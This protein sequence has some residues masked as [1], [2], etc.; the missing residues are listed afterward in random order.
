MKILSRAYIWIIFGLLYAP[1]LMLVLFSFNEAGS[2]NHFSS[3]SLKRDRH[4]GLFTHCQPPRPQAPRATGGEG[5]AWS[6]RP[7]LWNQRGPQA[8]GRDLT[9][10]ASP[11]RAPAA[12]GQSLPGLA[13]PG[14][15]GEG[16]PDPSATCGVSPTAPS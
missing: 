12:L 16:Q 5:A 4:P 6:P 3:F 9:R 10:P 8:P 11:G 2:L 1:I 15:C 13:A 7:H 14:S